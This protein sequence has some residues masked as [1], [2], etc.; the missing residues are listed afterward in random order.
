M[1]IPE[2]KKKFS[3]KFFVIIGFVVA[4]T[5]LLIL[6]YSTDLKLVIP[7]ITTGIIGVVFVIYL[8][9]K[10]KSEKKPEQDKEIKQS[11]SEEKVLE[12]LR[13]FVRSMHNQIEGNIQPLSISINDNLIYYMKVRLT[14]EEDLDGKKTDTCWIIINATYPNL[15]PSIISGE[16]AEEKVLEKANAKSLM[17][18]VL[19][20]EI[21]EEGFDAYGKPTRIIKRKTHGKKEEKD[22]VKEV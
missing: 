5:I 8:A 15:M 20:E 21:S 13:T 14:I 12:K 6:H 3:W 2:V 7:L 9:L 22:E 17:P 19:D 11:L 16:L 1:E 4:W 18:D 10:K